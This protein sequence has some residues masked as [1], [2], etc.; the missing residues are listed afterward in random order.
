MPDGCVTCPPRFLPY[1]SL[2]VQ[3]C[4]WAPPF[5]VVAVQ[6]PPPLVVPPSLLP[7]C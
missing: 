2:F 4:C 5:P 6:P 7:G 1:R 3:S